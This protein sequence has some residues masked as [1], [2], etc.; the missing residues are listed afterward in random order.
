[1]KIKSKKTSK[2]LAFVL[3]FLLGGQTVFA[4]PPAPK[5]SIQAKNEK[6]ASKTVPVGKV[7][8]GK[9]G[10]IVGGV[11]LPSYMCMNVSYV[12]LADLKQAGANVAWDSLTGKTVIHDLSLPV[13]QDPIFAPLREG[14]MG[15]LGRDAVYINYQEVPAIYVGNQALIP[16]KWIPS[17]LEG[18]KSYPATIVKKEEIT[19]EE[20]L[21]EDDLS[22]ESEEIRD[23][24]DIRIEEL[25]EDWIDYGF[26]KS[27]IKEIEVE[28]DQEEIF[29]EIPQD[30]PAPQ[31]DGMKGIN[32][33]FNGKDYIEEAYDFSDLQAGDFAYY[34]DHKYDQKSDYDYV[35]FIITE[36]NGLSNVN[37]G[38]H[39]AWLKNPTYHTLP[40]EV[41]D[42]VLKTL[43]PDTRVKGIMKYT[44]GGFAKGATVDVKL[45]SSNKSYQLFAANGKTIT[46]PWN[47][48]AI[49]RS[50]VTKEEATKEQIEAYINSKDFSSKTNYFVWTDIY[51]Q[52]TYVF[53]G[54]MNKWELVRSML[55][56]TGKDTNLTPIGRYTLNVRVPSF[57][58]NKYRAKNAYGFIGTT[59]LYHSVLYDPTGSYLLSGWGQLGNKASSGCIRLSPENS[60]WFYKTMPIGTGIF[61]N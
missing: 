50:P 61:I 20:V 34:K 4:M 49:Q 36:V 30:I 37:A 52:R 12:L 10:F 14:A 6:L 27:Q 55:S 18:D 48:V 15:Y 47:S 54:S 7:N 53:K 21:N 3:V 46:V 2:L 40:D 51:R 17:L 32:I 60:A 28:A 23:I 41:P 29:V 35:G 38:H 43:F 13:S 9:E 25:E 56:S 33:W 45:A 22:L 42:K 5:G 1:M 24:E 19:K 31:G 11:Y 39:T 44:A 58:G 59:Y 16:A 57:G 8:K 26:E